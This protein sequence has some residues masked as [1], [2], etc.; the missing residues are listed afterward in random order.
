MYN[1]L[2]LVERIYTT[3]SIFNIEWDDRNKV[4]IVNEF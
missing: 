1:N 4:T 3:D 2:D